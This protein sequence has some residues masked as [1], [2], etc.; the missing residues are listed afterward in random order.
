M[1]LLRA[2]VKK[3]VAHKGVTT[4]ETFSFLESGWN[5]CEKY[6]GQVALT[7]AQNRLRLAEVDWEMIEAWKVEGERRNASVGTTLRTFEAVPQ[8]IMDEFVGLYNDIVD[9]VPLGELEMREKVTPASRREDER[10]AKEVGWVWCTRV[11]QE[12]DGSVSGLT[13]IV[14]D[15]GLPYRVEQELTGVRPKHRGR[16][17]GKWLKAEMLLFVRDQFPEVKYVNTGNADTNAPMM[18]INE[19]MGFRRYHTE[20]CYRF[21]LETLW[22]SLGREQQGRGAK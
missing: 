10:R 14:Y 6:G 15:P 7:A 20:I 19:R 22:L 18:S 3:A 2:L 8:E 1:A 11:S 21:E 17:L 9:A 16:G 5:F 13:E 4:L 12:A